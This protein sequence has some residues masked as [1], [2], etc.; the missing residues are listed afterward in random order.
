MTNNFLVKVETLDTI[1]RTAVSA[2]QSDQQRSYS[3]LL[4]KAFSVL[5]AVREEL[6]HDLRIIYNDNEQI[7]TAI[8]RIESELMEINPYTN[9]TNFHHA[10]VPVVTCTTMVNNTIVG[11]IVPV[12]VLMAYL[13]KYPEAIIA[14]DENNEPRYDSHYISGVRENKE[15]VDQGIKQCLNIINN[16]EES[17]EEALETMQL[18]PDVWINLFDKL[19]GH[20]INYLLLMYQVCLFADVFTPEAIAAQQSGTVTDL[21]PSV[22][23]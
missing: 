14:L 13:T 5:D 2:V 4:K 17:I 18:K 8:D 22:N 23:Y 16:S 9:R 3:E 12:D 11:T 10:F 15:Q 19:S 6:Y 21:K 1:F 20:P 7:N